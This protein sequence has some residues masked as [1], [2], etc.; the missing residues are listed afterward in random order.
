M[1][2]CSWC[3]GD[4][5]YTQYHN[6]EWG[7]PQKNKRI[8][9]EFLILE[10]AQAGLSWITILK[11]REGYRAA[12]D[13]FCP[14]KIAAWPDS[15]IEELMGDSRIIRNRLK[16]QSA[17]KNAQAYLALEREGICFSEWIWSFV[18][19]APIDNARQSQG[20]VPA[21]TAISIELSKALK[22]RGFNFVGPT[23]MYAFMQAAGL[24]NDHITSCSR[25][26]P[27]RS[28]ARYE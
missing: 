2:D 7:V 20:D 28:L 16:I 4:E 10:G 23:I 25:Y 11:R 12:Y 14:V 6:Q 15:K 13:H 8:L 1:T 26:Q 3:L 18:G 5:L 27:C 21:Q 19:G 9:F 22:K 24:V 17:R